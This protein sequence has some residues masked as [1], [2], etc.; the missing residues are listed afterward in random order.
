VNGLGYII[1]AWALVLGAVA[2]YALSLVQRGRTMTRR[3]PRER[4]RWMSSEGDA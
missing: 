1:A 4:R 3:V 2:A